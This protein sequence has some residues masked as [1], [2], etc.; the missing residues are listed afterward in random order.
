MFI[1]LQKEFPGKAIGERIYVAG[2]T[3]FFGRDAATFWLRPSEVAL[4]TC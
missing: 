1:H 4:T 2:A 3:P